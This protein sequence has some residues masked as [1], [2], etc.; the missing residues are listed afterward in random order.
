LFWWFLAVLDGEKQT[1]YSVRRSEQRPKR[2]Y[3]KTKPILF[4]PQIFWGLQTNLKKQSQF[5]RGANLHKL[6]FERNL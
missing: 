6:L 3:E 5:T 2:L 1:Q 4:S